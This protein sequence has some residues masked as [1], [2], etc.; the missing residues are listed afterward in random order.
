MIIRVR[1]IGKPKHFLVK[2]KVYYFNYKQHSDLT[3]NLTLVG[4]PERVVH[5]KNLEHLLANFKILTPKKEMR[6]ERD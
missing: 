5:L 4:E 2:D 3:I 1:Y 6:H